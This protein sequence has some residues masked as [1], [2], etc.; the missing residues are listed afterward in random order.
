MYPVYDS[1]IVRLIIIC[2]CRIQPSQFIRNQAL[3]KRSMVKRFEERRGQLLKSMPSF[4]PYEKIEAELGAMN[5]KEISK[6][7]VVSDGRF[8][9]KHVYRNRTETITLS[10][11]IGEVLYLRDPIVTIC[12]NSQTIK[13]MKKVA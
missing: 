9:I 6:S 10:D 1:V 5:F 2:V 11:E 13:R 7:T 8:W 12:G 3:P 4:V